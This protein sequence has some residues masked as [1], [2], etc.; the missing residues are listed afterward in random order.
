[1]RRR[2]FIAGLGGAVASPL[3]ARAQQGERVGR[4]GYLSFAGD[5]N[6]IVLEVVR[7]ELR[8]RGW[9]E[10]RN[11][12]L[13]ARFGAGD[14]KRTRAYAAQLVKLAPDVVV[15][16]FRVAIWAMQQETKTVPIVGL[17][18]GDPIENRWVENPRYPEGNITRHAVII[19][20]DL[21]LLLHVEIAEQSR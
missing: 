8:K 16:V 18:G 9:I 4:V 19:L 5:D 6:D 14:L 11:L 17:G 12:R 3:V 2:E 7:D 21:R 15:A 20:D 10:G 1:M 13:D